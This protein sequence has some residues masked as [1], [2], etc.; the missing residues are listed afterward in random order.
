[1]GT[2]DVAKLG[3]DLSW[4][5]T[6]R[7]FGL[8]SK[9]VATIVK[10]P[11]QYGLKDRARPPVHVIGIDEVSRRKGQVYLTDLERNVLLWVGEE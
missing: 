6:T 10:R 5:A 8:N 3:R 4:Q 2:S 7:Q 1:M 11:V 9:S